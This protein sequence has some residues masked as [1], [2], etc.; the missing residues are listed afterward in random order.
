[1][2][3]SSHASSNGGLTWVI[4]NR[5]RPTT[6]VLAYCVALLVAAGGWINPVAAQFFPP[7]I[8]NPLANIDPGE[9][10]FASHVIDNFMLFF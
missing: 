6:A 5:L 3:L 1:M 4:P 10:L 9:D 8:V 2:D 7:G